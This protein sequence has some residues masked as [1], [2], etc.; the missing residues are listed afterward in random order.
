MRCLAGCIVWISIF[1]ILGAVIALGFIFAYS[2]GL[3]GDQ[4]VSYMGYTVP[5]ITV[6]Q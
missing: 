2:G 6:Q 3:F 4:K 1:G 5:K